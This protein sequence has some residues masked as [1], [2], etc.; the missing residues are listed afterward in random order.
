MAAY[1]YDYG[2]GLGAPIQSDKFRITSWV[3]PRAR[4]ATSGGQHSST[5]HAGVDISTPV[6]TNLL[7]P[8]SGRVIHVVNVNDGTQKRNQR[9]YG[10][11]VVIQR[12]DGVITQQSHL[13]DVNVKVGD[14]VQ[15]GQ[16]IGRTGNSGSST[17]PHLDY[18]VIKNGMA[19][20]PDGTA[21][22]AYQKSWLP[23][24]GT[25]AS[26]TAPV[27][28]MSNYAS[29]VTP[30]QVPSLVTPDIPAPAKPVA[31][32]DFLA[33]LEKEQAA[34]DKLLSLTEP[35]AG[36]VAVP[37]DDFYNNVA[38]ADWNTYYGYPTRPRTL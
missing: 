37:N 28:D 26:P 33:E 32:Q 25:M 17:G 36:A 12:D 15:Q 31:Q 22:R 5:S 19:M 4:F 3:G 18:I 14:R 34:A 23:K 11:Q 6:G 24:A 35:R 21:Y 1:T 2:L 27:G 9:G 10:N 8:M 29:T 38:Q 30:A 20:R 16:V 7:A 13:F